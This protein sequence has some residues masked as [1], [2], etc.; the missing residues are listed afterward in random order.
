[1]EIKDCSE[2]LLEARKAASGL[3][4]KRRS[5]AVEATNQVVIGSRV[6]V[7]I[8]EPEIHTI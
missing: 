7:T 8:I 5:L 3:A 2:L 6:T 1:M 4:S